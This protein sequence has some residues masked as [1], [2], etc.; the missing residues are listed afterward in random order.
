MSRNIIFVCMSSFTNETSAECNTVP[1]FERFIKLI[2]LIVVVIVFAL[3]SLCVLYCLCSFVCCVLFECGVLFCVMC[4]ICV[5]SYCSTLP[6]GKHP[7]AVE[8][9]NNN[10]RLDR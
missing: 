1:S 3:Y 9:S 2:Y 5:L 10:I 7:F 6:P 8:I 4:V